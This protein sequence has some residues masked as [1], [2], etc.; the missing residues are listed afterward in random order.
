MTIQ[1]FCMTSWGVDRKC[2]YKGAEYKIVS[3]NFQEK[4]VALECAPDDE[5]WVRCENITLI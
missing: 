4:L 1:E 5:I 2:M 3:V